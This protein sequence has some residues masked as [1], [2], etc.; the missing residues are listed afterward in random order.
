MPFL[1]NWRKIK[2][3]YLLQQLTDGTWFWALI[4]HLEFAVISKYRDW[5]WYFDSHNRN[6]LCRIFL[7]CFCMFDHHN[8]RDH[9]MDSA[10]CYVCISYKSKLNVWVLSFD[11]PTSWEGYVQYI[12]H[13]WYD[14]KCPS[15]SECILLTS[16]CRLAAGIY[17]SISEDHDQKYCFDPQRSAPLH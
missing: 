2:F 5:K 3:F 1:T 6:T 10:Q 15:L 16:G 11:D 17:S 7:S 13:I 4:T 9:K 12:I 8:Q 14:F